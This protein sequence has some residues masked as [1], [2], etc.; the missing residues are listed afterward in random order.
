MYFFVSCQIYQMSSYCRDYYLY[1][2]ACRTKLQSV[3]KSSVNFFL[4]LEH[5]TY[6]FTTCN[7]V[8]LVYKLF[9]E[10]FYMMIGQSN[11]LQLYHLFQT[12]PNIL[13]SFNHKWYRHCV[14]TIRIGFHSQ[15]N[16]RTPQEK[17]CCTEHLL[18][19]SKVVFEQQRL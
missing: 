4:Y 2:A 9:E 1:S 6:K 13:Y 16:T 3:K 19:Y 17:I 11:H 10:A 15:C 7:C 8:K 5:K 12:S 18:N 14:D